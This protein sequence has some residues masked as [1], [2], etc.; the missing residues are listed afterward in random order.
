MAAGHKTGGRV[1]GT[2]NKVSAS[3]KEAILAALEEAGGVKY[4]AGVAREN[5][6]VFCALL[7]RLLPNEITGGDGGQIDFQMQIKAASEKLD[8]RLDR[9]RAR[10]ATVADDPAH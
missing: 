9:I 4:L 10:A 8:A 5:P 3:V 2:P 6:Q 1:R 7:G